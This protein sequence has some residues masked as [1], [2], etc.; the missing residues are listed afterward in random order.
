[1]QNNLIRIPRKP[2]R[3]ASQDCTTSNLP[4]NE[5]Q[6]LLAIGCLVEPMVG[7]VSKEMLGRERELQIGIGGRKDRQ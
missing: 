5:R 3:R 4:I 1:M 2:F 7:S 6:T